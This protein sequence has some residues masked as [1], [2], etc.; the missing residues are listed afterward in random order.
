MTPATDIT[1]PDIGLV[2]LAGAPG[3]G[4]S[5]FARAQFAPG[6]VF[7]SDA[8]RALVSGDASDQG[9]SADAFA[10]LEMIVAA[11]AKRGLFTVVDATNA[12][13]A[14]RA[15]WARVA[16][17][18][19]VPATLVVIDVP[20][21]VALERVA[22]RERSG[23]RGVPGGVVKQMAQALDGVV[24]RARREGFRRVRVV[25]GTRLGEVRVERVPLPSDA[26]GLGGPFDIIG[27]VHGCLG[28]LVELLGMLGYEVARDGAGRPVGA[29]HPSGRRAVFV[30]DLVDRGPDSPGV[31]RLVMGMRAAGDALV[32]AGNHD[33]KLA[34]ALGGEK[35]TLNHGLDKTMEQL[36]AVVAAGEP[37]FPGAVREFIGALPEHLV[38]D[39]GALVIA[40]AGLKE[41][42]H[43]RESGAV[44]SFALY[45]D[46]T[47]ERTPQGFPVRRAWEAE[48]SGAATVVYGHTPSTAA[49]WVNNTICV[50]T[51]CVFG[52]SLTALR[53][54]D[55]ELAS[56]PAAR[57]WAPITAPLRDPAEVAAMSEVAARAAAQSGGGCSLSAGSES[58]TGA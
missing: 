50:D 6:E 45:G 17:E 51:A 58:T 10:A 48:Y 28:E 55:R 43:G 22:A 21:A 20:V 25:D 37:R 15:R 38:L 13:K 49:G 57:A 29:A 3:S 40:H 23:G 39:G 18:H 16:K 1:V 54:P 26:R 32:V 33:V 8:F 41:A 36:D 27:D 9:A 24:G 52:G 35:V 4:K 30:G 56:V 2:V 46:V 14:D 44:R 7:S 11:R 34:R 47:G 12:A 5:T 42:F 19:H 31:L 53:Y